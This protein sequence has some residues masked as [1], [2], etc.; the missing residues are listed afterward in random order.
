[1]DGPRIAAASDPETARV[2]L[3]VMLVDDHALVRSA[4]RQ[5]IAAPDVELV[6]EAGSA[7]DAFALALAVRPDVML[8]DIDLPGMNGIQMLEE[9][10]PRLPDTKIVMLTVSDSERDMIEALARGAAGYLTKG[11][12]EGEI[13]A[14]IRAVHRGDQYLTPGVAQKLALSLVN[15][16]D[17]H[18]LEELTQ[19]ETRGGSNDER[20]DGCRSCQNKR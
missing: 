17:R 11:C 13:V 8:L 12:D 4:V 5:A 14:A 15:H 9:L 20:Y 2:P 10:S 3:R 18:P 1:M 16:R 6:G 19:R 7:E